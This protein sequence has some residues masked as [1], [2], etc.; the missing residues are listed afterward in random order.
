MMRET[1]LHLQT[2]TSNQ[3]EIDTQKDPF[4]T[5]RANCSLAGRWQ[6]VDT[7]NNIRTW[8][9]WPL[10]Q[11]LQD[12]GGEAGVYNYRNK[13]GH[14]GHPYNSIGIVEKWGI[15]NKTTTYGRQISRTLDHFAQMHEY[16]HSKVMEGDDMA[17]NICTKVPS[18][19]QPLNY[20]KWWSCKANRQLIKRH[21]K[22]QQTNK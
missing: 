13:V 6:A 9:W 7:W 4:P 12:K 11:K 17:T 8:I 14:E 3:M 18:R 10:W 15:S 20:T 21:M 22:M 16:E 5:C 2:D 1:L 19:V